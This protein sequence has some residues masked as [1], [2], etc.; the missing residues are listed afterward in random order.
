MPFLRD[1]LPLPFR[2]LIT[3][4]HLARAAESIHA[5]SD[6]PEVERCFAE[7]AEF[8]DHNEL[9]CALHMLERACESFTPSRGTFE[10]LAIAAESMNLLD[11]A[12]AFRRLSNEPKNS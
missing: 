10:L 1:F 11:R 9:E 4:R 5:Q 12:A 2:W 8:L 6:S 3:R 7:Y